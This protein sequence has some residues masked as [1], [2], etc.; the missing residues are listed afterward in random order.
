MARLLFILP[1]AFLLAFYACNTRIKADNEI[2]VARV[3]DNYLFEADLSGIITDNTSHRDSIVI[4][5]SYINNWIKT[6]L[7]VEKAKYNLNEEQIDFE[8]RLEEYKN[9]LIIFEYESKLINQNLDT[10]ISENELREFYTD[11]LNDF[12]LKENILKVF[13]TI[14]DKNHP[15]KEIIENT[16]HLA[17]SLVIDSLENLSGQYSFVA[18]LDTNVW[19]SF[20]DLKKRVPIE[21]YNQEFFLKNKRFIKILD[22]QNCFMLKIVDFKITD[23]TSPFKLVKKNIRDIILA[24]RKIELIK[25]ARKDIF[26]QAALN[27]DFEIYYHE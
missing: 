10:T 12:E 3:F 11:H 8:K 16:Y 20:D 17:D 18:H 26:D 24:K 25:K 27:N 6:Q 22:E 21:T 1:L 5:R 15:E 2:V 9:S 7:M 19:I 23:D 4:V 14:I 13:Y